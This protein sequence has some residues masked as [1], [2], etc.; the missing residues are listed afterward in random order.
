MGWYNEHVKAGFQLGHA[1][2]T[3]AFIVIST[4][5]FFEKC[6]I[7]FLHET[8]Q[9]PTNNASQ[10]FLDQSITKCLSTVVQSFPESK[11]NI[12]HDYEMQPGTRRPKV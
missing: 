3:L 7:P 1:Y 6:F 8:S 4:P 10:D 2:D 11:I 9:T 12:M 5:S